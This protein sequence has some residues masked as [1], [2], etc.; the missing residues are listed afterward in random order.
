MVE[1][2]IFFYNLWQG[3]WHIFH[4]HTQKFQKPQTHDAHI[5]SA[6]VIY[7]SHPH[8]S[9]CARTYVI[10]DAHWHRTH[11]GTSSASRTQLRA[12][13]GVRWPCKG[14]DDEPRRQGRDASLCRTGRV[15]ATRHASALLSAGMPINKLLSLSLFLCRPLR[16]LTDRS[17]A[18][19]KRFTLVFNFHSID[20]NN[21]WCLEE[22]QLTSTQLLN[23]YSGCNYIHNMLWLL[24]VIRWS[25]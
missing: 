25:Q 6:P 17:I 9:T 5:M 1:L 14:G 18:R 12:R 8:I 21:L 4:S 19:H 16:M 15:I 3:F 10:T 20:I 22:P 13:E 2:C 7:K 11:I 24:C 23:D